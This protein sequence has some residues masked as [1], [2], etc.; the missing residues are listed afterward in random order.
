M[1]TQRGFTLVEIALVLSLTLILLGFITVNLNRSQQGASLVAAEQVLLS[2]LKQQQLKAMIGDTEGRATSDP[3]GIHF[4]SNQYVL[5]H[6]ATYSAMDNTNSIISLANNMQFDSPNFNVI[7]LKL[8]GEISAA[9]SVILK[10]TTNGNAKTI[11]INRY[12]VVTQG[13]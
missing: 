12:G 13:D 6:G 7:F 4:D 9:S 5:F 3:Y 2:D 1:K 8:S 11:M 10:D